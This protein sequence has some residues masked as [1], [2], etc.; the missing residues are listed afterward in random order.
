VGSTSLADEEVQLLV[1][2]DEQ[3]SELVVDEELGLVLEEPGELEEHILI[4]GLE[5]LVTLEE[6]ALEESATF[7]EFIFLAEYTPEEPAL[8]EDALP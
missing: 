6:Q 2:V 8:E 3:V 5:E 7:E 1:R 4:A